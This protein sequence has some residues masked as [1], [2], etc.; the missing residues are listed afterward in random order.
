MQCSEAIHSAER[1]TAVPDQL[2]VAI[3]HVES[4]RSDAQGIIRPWP[5]TINAGGDGHMFETKAEA[6]AAV[7]ALQARGVQSVDVGCMQV[8]LM[9]HPNAFTSL[10][11]AFDPVAN[12][13]YAAR[14]LAEL[15]GQTHS[16]DQA[17]ARYHSARPELGAEYQRK[18][19]AVLPVGRRQPHDVGDGNVW[20]NNVDAERLE[21]RPGSVVTPQH[22]AAKK[23]SGKA[24]PSL[25]APANVVGRPTP[26][27][28]AS[29]VVPR[30]PL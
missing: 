1:A 11:Q 14:F 28:T 5:W 25:A 22:A 21:H 26:T 2:M 7:Q 23:S 13:N 6:I 27:P 29:R 17:T 20:T 12:V 16:W 8:N 9:Y 10:D 15:Y 19:A 18:V 30:T 24:I 4:G 3:G